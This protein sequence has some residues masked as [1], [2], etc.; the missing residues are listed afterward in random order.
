MKYICSYFSQ[1][2]INMSNSISIE[3]KCGHDLET[4]TPATSHE[5][6][7]FMSGMCLSIFITFEDYPLI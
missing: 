2:L 3:A 7:H 5:L 1:A 4:C 6:F